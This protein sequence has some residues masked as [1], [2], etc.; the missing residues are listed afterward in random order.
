MI[1]KIKKLQTE[2]G[3]GKDGHFSK[4]QRGLGRFAKG[5]SS[6]KKIEKTW[7]R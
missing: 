5:K 1:S 2:A 3:T 7:K 4:T 6:W